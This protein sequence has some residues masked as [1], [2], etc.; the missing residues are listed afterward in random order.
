MMPIVWAVNTI[1][2]TLFD[3][4][5]LTLALLIFVVTTIIALAKYLRRV[6]PFQ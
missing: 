5:F 6:F 3:N 1:E 2:V 4:T